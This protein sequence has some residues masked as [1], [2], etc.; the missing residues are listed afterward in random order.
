MAEAKK[1]KKV[2]EKPKKIKI[3]RKYCTEG[4]YIVQLALPG[5]N[6]ED[7]EFMQYPTGLC[8]SGPGLEPWDMSFPV[9][10][11]LR[12]ECFKYEYSEKGVL[13]LMFGLAG[14]GVK[15]RPLKGTTK[16]PSGAKGTTKKPPVVKVPK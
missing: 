12:D 7:L 8:I 10:T 13:T 5:F 15:L 6:L 14:R 1:V 11:D 4:E 3:I 16:K 2:V 9:E